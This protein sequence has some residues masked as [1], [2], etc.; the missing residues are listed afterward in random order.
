MAEAIVTL[1]DGRKARLTGTREQIIAEADRLAQVQPGD[2]IPNGT[3]RPLPAERQQLIPGLPGTSVSTVG[4]GGGSGLEALARS[5]LESISGA[6][7]G[8]PNTLANVARRV[9]AQ[10]GITPPESAPSLADPVIPTP[11]GQQ[12][13]AG[14]ETALEAPVQAIQGQDVNLSQMFGR[15]LADAEALAEEHPLADAL[16]A[17]APLVL[18][19]APMARA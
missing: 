11:S 16:G 6:V 13:I 18:G 7:A 8:I 9:P 15:N 1:P 2:I 19:R 3:S 4:G 17:A 5:G 10:L 14:A 12:I